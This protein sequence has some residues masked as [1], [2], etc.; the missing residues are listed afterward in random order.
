MIGLAAHFLITFF[1][2]PTVILPARKNAFTEEVM[3]K[4]EYEHDLIYPGQVPD[5]I[6]NPDQGCGWYSK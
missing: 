1:L 6:G 2:T 4:F 5:P 3:K